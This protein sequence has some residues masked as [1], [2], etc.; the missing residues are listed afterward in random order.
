MVHQLVYH[1]R[2][3]RTDTSSVEL[4]ACGGA[5]FPPQLGEKMR[6]LFKSLRE[7]LEGYGLS[8]VVCPFDE[9]YAEGT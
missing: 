9:G 4:V 7:R 6:K 1:D 8:E 5:H 3:A 2:T